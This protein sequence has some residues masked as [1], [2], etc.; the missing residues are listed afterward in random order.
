MRSATPPSPPPPLCSRWPPLARLVLVQRR[1]PLE[2][3]LTWRFR[4]VRRGA[5]K[6]VRPG[7][8]E[9][10]ALTRGRRPPPPGPDRAFVPRAPC[11][12]LRQRSACTDRLG[13]G[14]AQVDEGSLART[15]MGGRDGFVVSERPRIHWGNGLRRRFLRSWCG[16]CVLRMLARPRGAPVRARAAGASGNGR[17]PISAAPHL[18]LAL[19]ASNVSA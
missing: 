1:R 14:G 6:G 12:I 3:L 5:P 15:R 10:L 7:H 16:A 19:S 4:S 11:P 2:H 18:L 13:R 9:A 8:G 17:T